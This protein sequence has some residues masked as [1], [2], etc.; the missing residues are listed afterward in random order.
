MI[1]AYSGGRQRILT[2]ETG[3]SPILRTRRL[4]CAWGR[5]F[6]SHSK[7]LLSGKNI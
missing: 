1:T 4:I 3:L 2:R 5:D 7:I 6:V